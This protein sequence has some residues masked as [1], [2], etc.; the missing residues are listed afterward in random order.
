MANLLYI[1]SSPRKARSH[2]SAVAEVF[3]T[4]YQAAHPADRI[5]RLDLWATDL[6]RFDGEALNAKY[7]IM[8]GGQPSASEQAAWRD[9]ELVFQ[10]FNASDKYLFSVPMWNFGLPYKLKK[11]IDVI[12]QPGLAW[13]FDPASGNYTGLVRGRATVIYSSGGMYHAGSGAEAFDL[14]KPAFQNWLSFIGVADVT[15]I[16]VAG[17]LF[18]PEAI[19]QARGEAEAQARKAAAIF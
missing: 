7:S 4:A 13:S 15:A 18:G 10:R 5:E 8:H 1:E 19:A 11:Y 14:Q 6:P 16:T 17:T 9:I 12:T 2:S 3:L